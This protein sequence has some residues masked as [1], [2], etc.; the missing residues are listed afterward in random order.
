MKIKRDE[1]G[2][3]RL[4]KEVAEQWDLKGYGTATR[5]QMYD[6]L[7]WLADSGYSIVPDTEVDKWI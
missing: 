6:V 4:P 1:P 7:W 2:R 5:G 3:V